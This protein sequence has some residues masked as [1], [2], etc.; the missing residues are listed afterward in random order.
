MISYT[1]VNEYINYLIENQ[2]NV[3]IIDFAIF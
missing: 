3:N 1:N 2:V